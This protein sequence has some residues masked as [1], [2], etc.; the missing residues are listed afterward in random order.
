MHHHIDVSL[1]EKDGT[2]NSAMP[3]YVTAHALCR[4]VRIPLVGRSGEEGSLIGLAAVIDLH[5]DLMCLLALTSPYLEDGI[6]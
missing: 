5:P 1:L 2:A 3:T 4:T 6:D